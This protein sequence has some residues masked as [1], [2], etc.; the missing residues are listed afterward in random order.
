MQHV[1]EPEASGDMNGSR[2]LGQFGH[3]GDSRRAKHA[4][5]VVQVGLDDVDASIGDHP[6]ESTL[7]VLLL[8]SGN[9]K[10][11]RIGYRLGVLEMVERAG[12]FEVDS[13]HL[14]QEAADRQRVLRVV[15]TVRVAMEVDGVAQRLPG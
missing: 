10:G 5:V 7:A 3:V 2:H 15:R 14:F 12:L 11:Q 13:P 9:R 6:A 1:D 8:S 4:P